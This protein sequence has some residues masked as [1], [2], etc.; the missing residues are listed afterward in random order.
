MNLCPEAA[1]LL[2]KARFL[3]EDIW[4]DADYDL[5][6]LNKCTS[7]VRGI[8]IGEGTKFSISCDLDE[9]HKGDHMY[10]DY[11]GRLERTWTDEEER[12]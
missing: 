2:A 4:E 5:S 11:D 8:P 9:G 1:V 3:G 12:K 6:R 7:R 10:L